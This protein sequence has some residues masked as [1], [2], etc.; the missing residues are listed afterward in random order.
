MTTLEDVKVT[1]FIKVLK[2]VASDKKIGA[3]LLPYILSGYVLEGN[4]SD[5]NY[6]NAIG[7]FGDA[8]YIAKACNKS[9]DVKNLSEDEIMLILNIYGHMIKK[10]K[11][12]ED[13]NVIKKNISPFCEKLVK[14]VR[15]HQKELPKSSSELGY[16]ICDIIDKVLKPKSYKG[17]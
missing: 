16:E 5:C 9:Y 8:Y 1:R 3:S 12:S 11:Y 15:D 17:K 7:L 13:Y 6:T 14:L 4:D 2:I 10:Y